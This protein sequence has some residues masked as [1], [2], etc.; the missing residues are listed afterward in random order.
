[1]GPAIN[2]QIACRLAVGFCPPSGT[3]VDIGAHIGSVVANVQFERSSARILSFEA[4]PEKGRALARKFPGVV[5]HCCALSDVDG[6]HS[7]FIDDHNS[8]CSSLAMNGGEVREITVSTKRLDSLCEEEH[9]DVMKIDVEGAELGSF[10]A[11]RW[12]SVAADP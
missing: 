7:F 11:Q 8:G 5:V 12:L 4:I 2:D 10:A 6:K 3:F 9:G 1:V